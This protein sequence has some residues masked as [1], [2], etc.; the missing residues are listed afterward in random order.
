MPSFLVLGAKLFG[1]RLAGVVSLSMKELT[2]IMGAV[3]AMLLLVVIHFLV[4]V[5]AKRRRHQA[6]VT[7]GVTHEKQDVVLQKDTTYTVAND[8]KAVLSAGSYLILSVDETVRAFNLRVNDRV[9]EYRH[10]T[11][12]VLT[13]GDTITAVSGN[14]ILRR[15]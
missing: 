2:I 11:K 1:R 9:R 5:M 7:A 13:V 15:A 12:L 10:N 8:K 4:V 3:A 14:V 6:A